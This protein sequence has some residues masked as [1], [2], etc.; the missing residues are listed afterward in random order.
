MRYIFIFL[1]LSAIASSSFSQQTILEESFNNGIP[2]NWSIIDGDGFTVHPSVG[3]FQPAWISIAEPNPHPSEPENRV[4]AST[5]YFDPEGKAFRFLVT[6]QLSLGAYGNIL[7]WRSRSHDP[8]FPDWIMVLVS[9][10]G[11]NLEDFTD[12][13]FRLNNEFPYW[14]ERSINLTDSGLVDMNVYLAFV[15]HTNQGFKLYVDDIMVEIN[16][17]VSVDNFNVQPQVV[18]FPNPSGGDVV[19]MQSTQSILQV[20]VMDLNGRI[21]LSSFSDDLKIDTSTLL[22]GVYFVRVTTNSGVQVVKY[23][24]L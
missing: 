20:E 18:L 17:P 21:V 12:T 11:N 5:S 10:T 19:Y 24:K 6:P 7:S 16:S 1:G 22:S 14:T 15:N 13:L 2:A 3:E 23:Q 9:T 4:A 8:S